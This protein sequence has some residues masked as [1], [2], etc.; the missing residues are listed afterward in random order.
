[1]KIN[2]RVNRSVGKTTYYKYGITIPNSIMEKLDWDETT[3]VK[4][5]TK[6][7]KILISK[8]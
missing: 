5:E 4:I 8:D 2:K 1:M 3:T 7:N 6:N